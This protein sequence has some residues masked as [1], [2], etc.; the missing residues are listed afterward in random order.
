MSS[1][2][3][4]TETSGAWALLVNADGADE[5]LQLC[6]AALVEVQRETRSK[7]L[8]EAIDAARN[9]YLPDHTGLAEDDAYNQAVSHV[10]AAIGTLTEG[11]AS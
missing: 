8:A 9:E 1:S 5:W 6:N 7:A 10:I 3:Q 4:N 2:S 11:G